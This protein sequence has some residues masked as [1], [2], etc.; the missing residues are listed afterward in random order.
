MDGYR[1]AIKAGVGS[2]MV[3]FSSLNGEKMHGHN[4]MITGVLKGELGFEGIVVSDWD[5]IEDLPG[6]YTQKVERSVNAGID[7]FM[8]SSKFREFIPAL[9]AAV[10]EGRVPMA[11]IDDAVRRILAIKFRMGLFERPF[12][13]P[14]LLDEVGSPDHRRVA[15]QA[16]RESQVLLVNKGNALPLAGTLTKIAVSGRAADDI[17]IQCGG[18]T[19]SWQGAAGRTTEGTTV[20]A[21]IRK[22]AP[23]ATVTYSRTGE[24]PRGSQVAI[25]VIGESPYAEMKGDRVDLSLDPE[26]VEAV[27]TARKAGIP[28]VVVL[29]SG[30]PMILEPIL[31][32]LD[33]LIAAWLPGSEGDGVADV[34]FGKYGPTGKLSMTWPKSMAQIPIN[35][36]TDGSRPKGALFDYGFGLTYGNLV[37]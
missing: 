7:M 10:E 31:S 28:V 34:L 33:A 9:K 19:I 1:A 35:V 23:Q 14:S 13:D 32:D 22:A 36:G 26:D 4:R 8:I 12:G 18:W 5:G 17:G 30:R 15:R 3:S 25:V 29:I 16:V 27:R 2:I 20:L 6:D 24:V 21:A 37:R 11:R